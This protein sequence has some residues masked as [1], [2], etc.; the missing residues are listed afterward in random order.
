M[1]IEIE[2]DNSYSALL[3]IDGR[4]LRVE[5]KPGEVSLE[6]IKS[7]ETE[8]TLGGIVASELFSKIARIQ[9]ACAAAYECEPDAQTWTN[10]S[11]EAAEAAEEEIW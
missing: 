8:N 5:S 6:G 1:K 11:E 9:Q 7:P 4:E 3:R 2:F 10:L